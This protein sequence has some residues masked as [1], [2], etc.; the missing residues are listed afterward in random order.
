MPMLFSFGNEIR[1]CAMDDVMK[2]ENRFCRHADQSVT[3]KVC[4]E[5]AGVF[6][7]DIQRSACDYSMEMQLESI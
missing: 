2:P 4:C 1:R 7:V 5:Y 6:S 3:T